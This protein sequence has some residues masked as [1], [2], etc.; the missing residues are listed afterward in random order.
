MIETNLEMLER[1]IVLNDGR[2][3]I[4]G[5]MTVKAK[6]D[7]SAPI[8]DFVAS[9]DTIDRYDEIIDPKGWQLDNYK[10]NPVFQ[11][12]H[13]YWDIAFTLGK[14]LVTEVR[15]GHLFQRIEFATGINPMAK[16][17]YE[18]YKGGF[19]NAVSVG[20]I[21]M[22]WENGPQAGAPDGPK[23]RR[24]FLRQELLE[25]SAVSVPANP[26]ALQQGLKGGA[27]SRGD[28]KDVIEQMEYLVRSYARRDPADGD[29]N[30]DMPKPMCQTCGAPMVCPSGH[31]QFSQK[32]G[33][34]ANAGAPGA[35][36][37][38]AL[39]QIQG[40]TKEAGVLLRRAS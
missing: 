16:M 22:E 20:F 5:L 25:L 1:L 33:S 10:K 18:L 11:N 40:F 38:G 15:D 30:G 8:I 37:N 39:L 27:I 31:K 6:A 2:K 19:L 28:L 34:G 24:K 4:R 14:S 13:N 21:P 29:G 26:N 17:S 3:G 36:S 12:S 7:P 32:A 9:D 35:G 23:Y